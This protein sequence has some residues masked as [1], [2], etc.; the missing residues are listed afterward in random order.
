MSDDLGAEKRAG[1]AHTKG[2]RFNSK[3][4]EIPRNMNQPINHPTPDKI[5]QIGFGFWPSKV[6]LSAIELG[7]FTLL[8]K[9]PA[10]APEIEAQLQLHPRATRD[11]LDTLVALGFLSRSGETYANTPDTSVFLDRAKPSYIGG[12]FEMA[13]ARLYEVWGHLG[14]ALR[15]GQAQNEA[16]G[17]DNAFDDLYDDAARMEN[18]LKAMTGISL[19]AARVIAQKFPFGDY[20]TFIDIGCAQGAVPVQVALAHPH[21][22]GGGFDLPAVRPVF[23]SYVQD[24]QLS[25]RVHFHAGDFFADSLPTADVL[26]MGHILH[27]WDLEQKQMLVRKAYE[28]LPQGGA[29]VVYDAIID[30]DRREN[31]FGLMMSLN[32]LLETPGGFDYTGADCHKWLREA[33]FSQTRQEHLL[34]PDSMIIGIK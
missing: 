13:N 22:T 23:E 5:M 30:D 14:E 17:S 6:L 1:V 10:T 19:G 31:A 29:L 18:F 9:T 28:A 26:V 21:L 25:D 12:I 27:D 11:F 8:E 2:R 33:G 4:K 16:K 32:M 15:T 3:T 20:K 34:G 7:L 24:H